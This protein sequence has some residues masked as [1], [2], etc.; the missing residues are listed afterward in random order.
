[1]SCDAKV[2]LVDYSPQFEYDERGAVAKTLERQS[3]TPSALHAALK[4]SKFTDFAVLGSVVELARVRERGMYNTFQMWFA[5]FDV[6]DVI[7]NV[8]Y[9]LSNII[10]EEYIAS[11]NRRCCQ[12]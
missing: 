12:Q 1:M 2:L 7:G 8:R 11:L 9:S 5:S 4:K 10:F 3:T 6:V